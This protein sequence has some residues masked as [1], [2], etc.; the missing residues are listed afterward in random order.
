MRLLLLPGLDG[1]GQL[2]RWLIER[3]PPSLQSTVVSYPSDLSSYSDLLPLVRSALPLGEPYVIVAESYSGPLAVSVASEKPRGLTGLVLVASFARSPWPRWISA[4]GRLVSAPL[5]RL[6]PASLVARA[7]LGSASTSFAREVRDAISGNSPAVLA[8]RLRGVLT[9][10]VTG[11]LSQIEVPL[12]YLVARKDAFV[13][14][15]AARLIQRYARRIRVV[16]VEA[17]HLLLQVAPAEAAREISEF[18]ARAV[19]F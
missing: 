2:F 14:G 13:T 7:L 11:K 18:A 15:S 1:T 4:F 17:P 3:L 9:V 6:L 16:T 8:G 5:L 12:L 19:A 10:D